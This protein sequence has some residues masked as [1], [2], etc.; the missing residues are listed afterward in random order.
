MFLDVLGS[1]EIF[2]DVF[3]C[4][5]GWRCFQMFENVLGN[6]LDVFRRVKM[7]ESVFIGLKILLDS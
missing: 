6:V 3:R 4:L 7:F 2:S 5:D 1:S